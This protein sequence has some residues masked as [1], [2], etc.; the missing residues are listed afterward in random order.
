MNRIFF[1]LIISLLASCSKQTNSSKIPPNYFAYY[2]D[3]LPSFMEPCRIEIVSKTN[4][5]R[6]KITVFKPTKQDREILF[7]DSTVLDK[8]DLNSFFNT[9]DSISL[10]KFKPGKENMGLDGI[11]V[12]NT[13]YSDSATNEFKFWSPRKTTEPKEH[14]IV[15]AVIELAR[16]KFYTLRHQEYFESLEQYFD[17]GL[18]C[19]IISQNPYEIR[20]YGILSIDESYYLNNF[21]KSLPHDKP[22]LIDMTN[23]QSMGTIFYPLFKNLT[24]RNKNVLWATSY[25]RQLKEIGV[26]TST[27]FADIESARTKLKMLSKAN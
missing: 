25:T 12:Y 2:A 8:V 20:I 14:K 3:F 23:F 15:E 7:T 17:Y 9:L 5:G 24:E 1:I 16:K 10:L 4:I 6:M 27:I 18:P 22:I 19:K 21:I 13:V 11:K 26:D